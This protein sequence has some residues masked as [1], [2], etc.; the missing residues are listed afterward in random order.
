ME[1]GA[2]YPDLFGKLLPLFEEHELY[3]DVG[4]TKV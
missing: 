2:A 4:Q 1:L 3:M